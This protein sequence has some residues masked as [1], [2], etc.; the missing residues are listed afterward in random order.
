MIHDVTKR[1]LIVMF[2]AGLLGGCSSLHLPW[3]DGDA[4][5]SPPPQN[6]VAEAPAAPG[7]LAAVRS[8]VAENA[9]KSRDFETAE[10]LYREAHEAS[11]QDAAPLSGLAEAFYAQG[12]YDK[13]V[14]TFREAL[15]RTPNSAAVIEGL[16]KSLISKGSYDEARTLLEAAAKNAPNGSLLNKLGVARDLSGDGQGAQSAYRAALALD[17]ENLSTRN[18][19]ALS[20]A[21]SG[22]YREAVAEMEQVAA[23]PRGGG[24]YGA[25]LAFVYGLAGNLAAVER[26]TGTTDA[27]EKARL[28][29]QYDRIRNLASAGERATVLSMITQ[30]TPSVADKTSN[31]KTT[32]TASAIENKQESAS[33][34]VVAKAEPP[35]AKPAPMIA[36]LPKAE[37]P[38]VAKAEPAAAEPSKAAAQSIAVAEPAKI[39]TAPV[40]KVA[41]DEAES[42]VAKIEAV[43]AES[44]SLPQSE[45]STAGGIAET[46]DLAGTAKPAEAM[47]VASISKPEPVASSVKS[48]PAFAGWQVQLGAYRTAVQADR[49]WK[50]LVEKAGDMLHGVYKLARNDLRGD[51]PAVNY[52]L[53]TPALPSKAAATTLCSAL[54]DREIDCLVVHQITG[55]WV[56]AANTQ[57]VNVASIHTAAGEPAAPSAAAKNDAAARLASARAGLAEAAA[58]ATDAET[59]SGAGLDQRITPSAG[60]PGDGGWRVQLGAYRSIAATQRG[61]N[62]LAAKAA[63]ILPKLEGMERQS[64]DAETGKGVIFRLRTAELPDKAAATMLCNVLRERGIACLVIRQA[65]GRWTTGG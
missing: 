47:K 29:A 18:N 26:L 17:P 15:A 61:L 16:A 36:D 52:R 44:A 37:A 13:A 14:S 32:D 7:G 39:E 30:Q 3:F 5:S 45:V 23:D 38:S 8:H 24:R 40:A 4:P 1:S 11:P 63:D 49:G 65:P 62:V 12:N 58:A 50:V 46:P 27:P 9:L 20:L 25:N 31:E 19:L 6:R 34:S 33:G 43:P 2:A 56:A 60:T 41:A 48:P 53:R 57:P 35:V 59:T 51:G 54:Q 10:R 22:Q 28:K 42:P 55:V 64:A 21:I